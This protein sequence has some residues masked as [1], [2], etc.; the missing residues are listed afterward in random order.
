[1]VI[2]LGCSV[3]DPCPAVRWQDG[4]GS[5][6][7]LVLRDHAAAGNRV[8]IAYVNA[9]HQ[10]GELSQAKKR[11]VET[12][13]QMLGC[14]M[15]QAQAL[16]SRTKSATLDALCSVSSWAASPSARCPSPQEPPTITG[17]ANGP[18]TR[19]RSRFIRPPCPSISTIPVF[20]FRDQQPPL[21]ETLVLRIQKRVPIS[22]PFVLDI[23]FCPASSC[24]TNRARANGNPPPP[25]NLR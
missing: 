11:R 1:M 13:T 4:K 25:R 5:D 18:V 7:K 20:P 3:S 2:A 21:Y 12:P 9:V 24:P 14:V 19:P 22:A 15:R 17:P 16:L 10:Q 6:V 8:E 23:C